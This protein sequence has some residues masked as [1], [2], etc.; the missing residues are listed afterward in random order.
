MTGYDPYKDR[1]RRRRR[2]RRGRR[3]KRKRA[4]SGKFL[5]KMSTA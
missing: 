3:S 2:R 1:R 5:C 4:S